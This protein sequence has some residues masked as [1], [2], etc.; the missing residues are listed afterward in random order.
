MAMECTEFAD[1]EFATVTHI[2]TLFSARVRSCW[3]RDFSS[4]VS[5]LLSLLRSG[6]S[7]VG[8]RALQLP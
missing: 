6:K 7:W 5:L 8:I 2:W 1:S 4:K 3:K